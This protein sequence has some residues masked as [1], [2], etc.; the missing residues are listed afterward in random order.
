MLRKKH[1]PLSLMCIGGCLSY[2]VALYLILAI[3][4]VMRITT[5][6]LPDT[7]EHKGHFILH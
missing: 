1:V 3:I 4:T 5:P 6:M 2:S 7:M